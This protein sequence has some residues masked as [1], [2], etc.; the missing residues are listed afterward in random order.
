MA[1]F[2]GAAHL[3]Y[4][5]DAQSIEA[6]IKA[7]NKDASPITLF[8]AELAAYHGLPLATKL[9]ILKVVLAD[10]LF[11]LSMAWFEGNLHHAK[12]DELLAL[13]DRSNYGN[14]L[15][16]AA[17]KDLPN[18]FAF[19]FPANT[20]DRIVPF[21]EIAAGNNSIKVVKFL[22]AQ[23]ANAT[24]TEQ[25][26]KKVVSIDA[27]DVLTAVYGTTNSNNIFDDIFTIAGKLGSAKV[28]RWV[29]ISDR[30][31]KKSR[32]ELVFICKSRMQDVIVGKLADQRKKACL[33][34]L[35]YMTNKFL[36]VD[37][38]EHLLIDAINYASVDVFLFLMRALR[39]VPLT[40]SWDAP[41]G[42]KTAINMA[43]LMLKTTE[44]FRHEM[45]Q[46]ILHPPTDLAWPIPEV[47]ANGDLL[48]R[49]TA[50]TPAQDDEIAKPRIYK[51][52]VYLLS[53]PPYSSLDPA[54]VPLFY[55]IST[56][57]FSGIAS[58]LL[59]QIA[60]RRQQIITNFSTGDYDDA[61]IR[62]ALIN[63]MPIFMAFP[64]DYNA[65]DMVKHKALKG[66]VKEGHEEMVK[67][68]LH[69]GAP[70]I[71]QIPGHVAWPMAIAAIDGKLEIMKLLYAAG[72]PL[73]VDDGYSSP[74]EN[75]IRIEDVHVVQWLLD[76]GGSAL[77]DTTN[78]TAI[79]LALSF[80]SSRMLKLLLQY[81]SVDSLNMSIKENAVL[82]HYGTIPK[83][84][85][86]IAVILAPANRY[87]PA[88]NMDKIRLMDNARRR[89]GMEWQ[90]RK[91]IIATAL[92]QNKTY[93]IPLLLS[94]LYDFHKRTSEQKAQLK[95]ELQELMVLAKNNDTV[96]RQLEEVASF[97]DIRILPG[98]AAAKRFK[99]GNLQQLLDAATE[100]GHLLRAQD[101]ADFVNTV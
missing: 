99:I 62:G 14:M 37:E 95:R 38:K 58:N 4:I 94:I 21:I 60:S 69:V 6:D 9:D 34:T 65:S 74:L 24:L 36:T 45:L 29:L 86:S 19:I 87:D 12:A 13:N 46:A 2:P 18:I 90:H 25:T 51:Y 28:M 47:R 52:L 16:G 15:Y 93:L 54:L 44:Y 82:L 83:S 80:Q 20:A 67:Y 98:R 73:H 31:G 26:L 92:E 1:A 66:A 17:Q 50:N 97:M 84:L 22:M 57:S 11:P 81:I 35:L 70:L 39:P 7:K 5:L 33:E 49:R 30:L 32:A 43:T 3:E 96:F 77:L 100:S 23:N 68:L 89:V 85:L 71:Y 61:Y 64:Q 79:E 41:T 88:N 55:A 53:R 59:V 76:V 56:A 42:E 75:A 48:L 27:I 101:L 40:V 63:F 72:S 10:E 91:E 8:Q 78:G